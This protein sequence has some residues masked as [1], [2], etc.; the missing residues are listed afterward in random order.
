MEAR[1]VSALYG[2][3]LTGRHALDD[4]ELRAL[5]AF[6]LEALGA[7]AVERLAEQVVVF[8][9]EHDRLKQPLAAPDRTQRAAHVLEQDEASA[10]AKHALGLADCG[11]IVGDRA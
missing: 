9:A 2:S 1:S 7:Q 10:R 8:E 11:A 6:D 3:W 5:E 4:A